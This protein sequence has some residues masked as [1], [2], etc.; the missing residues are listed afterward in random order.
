MARSSAF[1]TETGDPES[2]VKSTNFTMLAHFPPLPN[3]ACMLF[4]PQQ[5]TC[6]LP[7]PVF[8]VCT[9]LHFWAPTTHVLLFSAWESLKQFLKGSDQCT[10]PSPCKIRCSLFFLCS[11][12]TLNIPQ[13]TSYHIVLELLVSLSV[14]HQPE[15]SPRAGT[16]MVSDLR[17]LGRMVGNTPRKGK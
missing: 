11:H 10:L 3:C 12:R 16:F 14:F 5:C 8:P 15:N 1:K 4:P 7:D 2:H 9:L 6:S 13:Q 17:T